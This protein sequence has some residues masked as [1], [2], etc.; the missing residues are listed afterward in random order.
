M[1]PTLHSPADPDLRGLE[2][3][4][5]KTTLWTMA[6]ALFPLALWTVA[7]WVTDTGAEPAATLV[8]VTTGVSW[9]A[10]LVNGLVGVRRC[11][12]WQSRAPG[13]KPAG[14]LL[15]FNAMPAGFLVVM[16]LIAL[17]A[18]WGVRFSG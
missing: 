13:D 2:D 4:A 15:I 12:A 14:I 5:A 7:G 11:R 1:P 3:R 17:S 9:L 10:A 18:W 8:A 16:A 6:L